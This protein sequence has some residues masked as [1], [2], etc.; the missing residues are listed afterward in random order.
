MK[1]QKVLKLIDS[2]N[3]DNTKLIIKKLLSLPYKYKLK[4]IILIIFF[5]NLEIIMTHLKIILKVIG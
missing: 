2:Q 3:L 5:L 1:K 4:K